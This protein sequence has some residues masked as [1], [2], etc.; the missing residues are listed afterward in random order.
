MARKRSEASAPAEAAW[1]ANKVEQRQT[2]A[3][4]PYARNSR[5]HSDEQVQQIARSI[6][7]FGWTI[8]VLVDEQDG[9]IAGHAR[10][11]AASK[12]GIQTVPV[13]VA[14]GWSD[15]QKRA[16]VI[17]DN[18]LPMNASWN[19]GLLKLELKSLAEM[20]FDLPVLGFDNVQL[21][22]FVSGLGGGLGDEQQPID[23]GRLLAER[24]GVPPFT[25]LRAAEG[26]W[27]NRKRAWIALGIQSELGRG[28]NLLKF[29]ETVLEPDPAKRAA[30][31]A[32]APQEA[33]GG[34]V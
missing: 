24:F 1:P 4:V 25:V 5:V 7:E 9:I 29:S 10:V 11:M 21:T 34:A 6:Q 33:R 26:W 27:Q 16:Y 15:A 23:S 20:G 28:E 22:S 18:Q 13:L 30:R 3:L 12:L 14:R 19:E 2:S 31:K 17:A 32:R 8:P